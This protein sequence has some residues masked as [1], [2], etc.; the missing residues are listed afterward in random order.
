MGAHRSAVHHKDCFDAWSLVLPP[1]VHELV[2]V[3]HRL[4]VVRNLV[5]LQQIAQHP[6]GRHCIHLQS[7]HGVRAGEGGRRAN[8][9]PWPR[10][11]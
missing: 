2:E 7:V 1:N 4:D 10:R 9:P 8:S 6:C 5:S 11:S 3:G